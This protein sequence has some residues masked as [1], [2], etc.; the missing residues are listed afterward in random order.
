LCADEQGN[1]HVCAPVPDWHRRNLLE[2]PAGVMEDGEE[3]P[4]SAEREIREETG[5]GA[6]EM[7]VLGD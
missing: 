6:H 7:K 4:L 2:L 1:I 3:A 5:M